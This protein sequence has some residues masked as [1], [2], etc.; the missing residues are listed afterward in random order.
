MAPHNG[1]ENAPE[2]PPGETAAGPSPLRNNRLLV[3]AFIATMAGMGVVAWFGLPHATPGVKGWLARR[4]LPTMQEAVRN[5][6]WHAAMTAMHAARRWAPDDPAVLHACV[7]FISEAGGDPRTVISLVRQLQDA[8][9]ATPEDLAVMGR[10]YVQVN[11]SDKA[12][13]IMAQIPPEARKSPEVLHFQSML[14]KS[15][16]K[17]SEAQEMAR[18]ALILEGDSPMNLIKLARFDLFDSLPDRRAHIRERLWQLARSDDALALDA[19]AL[20]AATPDLSSPQAEE[21]LSL[22]EASKDESQKTTES[23]H[24]VLSARMR[25]GP[26]LR[27]DILE[28]EIKRWSGS[29]PGQITPLAAWLVEEEQHDRLLQIIPVETAATYPEL[30]PHYIAALRAKEKWRE[31]DQLLKSRKI[32]S[33]IPAQRLRLWSAEVQARLHKD[34]RAARQ[35]LVR[36]F[37]E[38]ERGK[39]P[40]ETLEAATLAEQF[41][42]YDFALRCYQALA[43][44]HPQ[45][46][47]QFLPKAYRMAEFEHDSMTMLAICDDLLAIKPDNMEILIQ[48]LYLHVLIGTEIEVV[49]QTIDNI[50]HTGSELRTDQIHLLHALAAFRQGMPDA[51]GESV[52]R[53]SH[54]ENFPT[55]Q[56]AVFAALLKGAGGDPGLAFRL[57]ERISPIL[58]LPEEKA[59]LKRAL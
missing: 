17:D 15:D 10:M 50:D 47:E 21:L 16:G 48:K 54:P 31:M 14:L 1:S 38:A 26:H 36:V 44:Q 27:N 40:A 46:R 33:A 4:H 39:N 24:R 25:I 20:L 37:E 30:F 41:H 59:F 19:V 52:R 7:E 9:A 45:L 56:R 3:L 34:M 32:D 12:R 13:L 6:D 53:I 18:E 2:V 58:L 42:F 5:R 43:K 22:V 49:Q 51:V 23:R 28:D 11:E 55:G 57:V 8:K 35:T 29:T